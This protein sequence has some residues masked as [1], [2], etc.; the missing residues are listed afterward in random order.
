MKKLVSFAVTVTKGVL[1]D[2]IL[3][4]ANGLTYLLMLSFFPFVLFLLSVVGFLNLDSNFLID[5]ARKFFP[6][7]IMGVIDVFIKEVVEV[8]HFGVLSMSLIFSIF[9]A[10]AGFEA[11]IRAI[12]K[13]YGV[14]ESRSFIHIKVLS[15]SLM[16]FLTV[17]ISLVLAVYGLGSTFAGFSSSVFV[18]FLFSTGGKLLG[19]L[20]LFYVL[21]VIYRFAGSKRLGFREV[22]LGSVFTFCLWICASVLIG[23]YISRFARFSVVYGSIAGIVIMMFWLNIMAVILLV[24]AKINAV[25]VGNRNFAV[26]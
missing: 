5:N 6:T 3:P 8:R 2:E 26:L 13:V 20:L 10:S 1:D 4:R 22:F 14:K 16:F 15:I 25:I 19:L 18:D 7:E 12:N 11:V 17:T 24:G 21:L 9:S 23:I